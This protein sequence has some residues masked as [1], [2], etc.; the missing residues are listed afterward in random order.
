[1]NFNSLIKFFQGSLG[2]SFHGN[3]DRN[4]SASFDLEVERIHRTLQRVAPGNNLGS[5][6][7]DKLEEL[8]K[9][10]FCLLTFVP[11]AN[12]VYFN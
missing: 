8:E 9:H 7:I 12:K 11:Y 1:M 5:P 2:G 4:R 6:I 3:V 10:L